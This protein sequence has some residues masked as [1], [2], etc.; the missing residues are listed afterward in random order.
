MSKFAIEIKNL[1]FSYENENILENLSMQVEKGKFALIIGEN[2]AGKTTLIRLIL[3][4]LKD[5]RGE[6]K[7]FSDLIEKSNHYKDLAYISQTSVQSYTLFPTNVKEVIQNHI[8][9]LHKSYDIDKLLK[10]FDLLDVKNHALCD[11]SGGQI[12]RLALILAFIK[13]AKL[14]ILDEP[15]AAIDMKFSRDFYERLKNLTN[16]GKT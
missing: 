11:L 10:D 15:T 6:I 4:Q 13:D 2:G 5:Y 14:L 7:I 16:N 12:Q 8:K 3:N 1:S 9:S